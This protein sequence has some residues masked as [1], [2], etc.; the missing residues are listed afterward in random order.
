MQDGPSDF[1]RGVKRPTGERSA[2]SA[3]EL[4]LTD[5]KSLFHSLDPSPLGN[6]DLDERVE[7]YIVESAEEMVSSSYRMA[8]YV[9]GPVPEGEEAEALA[10]GVRAYFKGRRTEAQR[11]LRA[12]LREGRQ[13]IV[14]GLA[15]LFVCGLL[16][17]L[18]V[19]ALP[20]PFGPFLDEGFLIIGWVANWRP[21]EIF[22][23]EWRPLRRYRDTLGALGEME[24]SF[25]EGRPGTAALR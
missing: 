23:Y 16:G 14:I 19:K 6:R 12:L 4:T 20:A 25:R 10:N 7:R 22:L 15:F 11:R 1:A 2:A 5:P 18:A 13:A 8:L 21:V 9:A 3:I 17:A 24:I